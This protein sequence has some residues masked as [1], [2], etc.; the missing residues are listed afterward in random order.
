MSRY[1]GVSVTGSEYPV[2]ANKQFLAKLVTYAQY[3][4]MILMFAGDWIFQKL[5]MAP[6]PIYYR[7]KEK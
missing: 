4:I 7:M 6:P 2:P 5:G 3:G 1:P